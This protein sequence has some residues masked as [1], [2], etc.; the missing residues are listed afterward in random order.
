[1]NKDVIVSVDAGTSVIKAIAFDVSGRQLGIA[2]RRNTY[3]QL[4]DGGV[5][6]DMWRTWADTASTLSDLGEHVAELPQRALALAVT[7]QGDGTWLLDANQE[8]V[9]DGWLWLDARAADEARALAESSAAEIVYRHTGS[10]IN[11]CQMR[12]HLNWMMRHA[13]DLLARAASAVHCKD[14]LYLNLTGVLASDPSE[15]GFTFGNFRTGDYSDEAIEALGL[16]HLRHLLPP[17]VDGS[18]EAHGLTADA[19]KATGL[20][21]GL[22]VV[23]GLIDVMCSAIG[24]GIC[25]PAAEPGLTVLGST[26]VHMRYARDADSVVLN[27]AQSGYTMPIPGGAFAQMQ[28]NMAATLNIDWALGIASEILRAEGVERRAEDL[29]AGVDRK[30]LAARPGAAMFHP[31]ISSAGERGPFTEPDARASFTGLDQST[32]WFEMLRAVYDG[33][34]LAARDCYAALGETP[35][36][37]RVT[38]GAARSPIIRQL[39]AAA[40]N[41][42]VR[43]IAQPEAGAAGAAMIAAVQQG[44]FGSVSDATDAWVLPLLQDPE[45]PDADLAPIYDRLFKAYLQSRVALAPVWSAQAALWRNQS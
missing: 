44:I 39:L 31:Y 19:A 7:G 13:P 42:P 9:H 21:Q 20:P 34:V 29:L 33:L 1:M 30:V 36:E 35:G 11:V 28:T 2:S 22:P 18:R 3:R 40:L 32:G 4:P 41:R 16:A 43:A 45:Q 24:A 14:W 12:T 10:G 25:D 5:E 15:A 26:G 38:G 27:E 6:Q 17:I 23:L 8:P 37:I